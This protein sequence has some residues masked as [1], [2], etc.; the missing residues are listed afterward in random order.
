MKH[1][2]KKVNTQQLKQEKEARKKKYRQKIFHYLHLI[3]CDEVGEL[4]DRSSIEA[5]YKARSTLQPKILFAE[6]VVLAHNSRHK[7]QAEFESMISEKTVEIYP[8]GPMLS[9]LE[10]NNFLTVIYAIIM[11]KEKSKDV[12]VL[13]LIQIFKDK[14]PDVVPIYQS[15]HKEIVT[16]MSFLGLFISSQTEQICWIEN[17]SKRGGPSLFEYQLEVQKINPERLIVVVDN[18]PRP[19]FRLC[20]AVP[21]MGLLEIS[22]TASQLNLGNSIGSIPIPVYVQSHLM[23]RLE[24]RLDCVPRF[25]REFYLYSCMEHPTV[26]H[27]HGNIL[28]EYGLDKYDKIGYLLVEYV[29][30]ILLVKTFLMLSN[31]GTPEGEKLDEISGMKKVDHKYWAI[32][33]LS[34]FQ[35]SD[36]KDNPKIREVFEKSGCEAL[37]KE[38]SFS[39]DENIRHTKQAQ[40]MLKFLQLKHDE[41]DARVES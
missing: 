34:T 37:F 14:A 30:G 36:M 23:H 8:G 6:G 5:M 12:N 21:K 19:V 27:F 3:D 41:E 29:D 1:R 25:M 10:V 2:K 16:A 28:V 33:R 4:M 35:H 39:D 15:S 13:R 17:I 26:I 38:I 32:D 31:S 20:L 9:P 7:V 11:A 40:Q 22:L 24:E 18:H